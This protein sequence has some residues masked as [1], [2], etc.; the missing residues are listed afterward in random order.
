MQ[1]FG[2]IESGGTKIICL[3]ASDPDHIVAETRI[4]TTNPED[5]I[6]KILEFFKPFN[7]NKQISAIGIASFG[8]VDLDRSSPTYGHITTTP[9]PGWKNIDLYGQIQRALELPVAFDTDVNAAAIGEQ[10]WHKE[11]QILDPFIYVTVGTGIGVG[12]LVNGSPLHGLIHAEA[13]HML[14]PHDLEKDPFSGGCPI[15]KDCWEGLASG[16]SMQKRWGQAA[17][18]LPQNHIGWDLE[19]DYIAR[20]IVNLIYVYSP[21]QIVIGGGVSQHV[22]LIQDVH[23]KVKRFNNGYIQSVMVEEKINEYIRAPFL[24]IR[25]GAMGAIAMAVKLGDA[26]KKRSPSIN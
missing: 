23:Q 15:H 21:R 22:G 24:G 8:P 25:S 1:L 2:G 19:S 17:E 5:T 9:K 20:A 14:I 4:P 12:V 7:T 26:M 18:T 6:R 3:V 10:Y 16:P 13:G 11:G